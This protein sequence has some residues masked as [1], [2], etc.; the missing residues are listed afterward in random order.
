[1]PTIE[2]QL[3]TLFGNLCSGRCYPL[4]APEGTVSPYITFQVIDSTP[5]KLA[6]AEEKTRLQADVFGGTYGAAKTL[7]VSVKTAL[8]TA[9]FAAS[10]MI[11]NMDL[12]EEVSKEYRV[13][14]EF[15][16]WPK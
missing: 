6:T 11:T 12:Y 5:W 9:T 14:L 4:I 2:A 10:S 3:Q 15:Y 7:A 16:I 13:L 8:D 1:M